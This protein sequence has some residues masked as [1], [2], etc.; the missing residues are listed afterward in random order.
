LSARTDIRPLGWSRAALGTLFLL[1]TTPIL[2]P[3]HIWFLQGTWPLLGWPDDRWSAPPTWF[4]LPSGLVGALCILRTASAIAFTLGIGTQLWGLVAGASGYLVLSQ[5]PFGFINTL[6]LLF[7]GTMLLACTDAGS[8]FAL[9]PRP[10]R[11]P[12]SSFA[13]MRVFLASIYFWAGI[14]KLRGEWLDGRTLSFLAQEGGFDG[15]LAGVLLAT[16]VRRSL[17][18]WTVVTTELAL[19]PLLLWRR[20]RIPSV[21][22]AYGFHAAIELTARP[23]LLGWEMA[24]LLVTCWPMRSPLGTGVHRSAQAAESRRPFDDLG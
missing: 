13:L 4:T 16:P 8:A 15:P 6:H 3:F 19:G 17:V 5:D 20:A 12:E 7:L 1:R 21:A 11:S 18:A 23:D 10:A 2:A 9:R 24:A 22:L 14:A